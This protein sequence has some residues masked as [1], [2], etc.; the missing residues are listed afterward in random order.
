MSVTGLW[1]LVATLVAGVLTGGLLRSRQGRVRRSAEEATG[2]PSLP[3]PVSDALVADAVTLVQLSTT[4]CAP[5]RHARAVLARVA[6]TTDGVAHVELDITDRPEV[7]EALRV[8]RT[9]TTIAFDPAGREL[10]RISGVPKP[11]T[12]RT[13]LAPHIRPTE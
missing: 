11:A 4:F 2:P 7:A 9:P 8:L 3:G 5:C 1:V 13:A 10:L 12:L 6:E